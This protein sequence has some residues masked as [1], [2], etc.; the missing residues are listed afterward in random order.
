MI[1]WLARIGAVAGFFGGCVL[2]GMALAWIDG[3]LLGR[4]E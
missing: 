1:L 2:L 4:L 3:K